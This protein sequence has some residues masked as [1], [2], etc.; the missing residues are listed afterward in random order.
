PDQSGAA[1]GAYPNGQPGYLPGRPPAGRRGAG[2]A[3]TSLVLAVIVLVVR[4]VFIALMPLLSYRLDM[5][6]SAMNLY[7]I[8]LNLTTGV[9]FVVG[10]VLSAIALRGDR[11]VLAAVGLG[12]HAVSL[13]GVLL[14]MAIT[15][16]VQLLSY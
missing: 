13:A 9:V 8:V 5:P 16:L 12:S 3:W 10:I 6:V 11:K 7:S 1:P 2:L 15:P 4:P 14:S